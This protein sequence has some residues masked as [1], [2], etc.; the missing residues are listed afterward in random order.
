MLGLEMLFSFGRRSMKRGRSGGRKKR[1][2]SR[3]GRVVAVA[4]VEEKMRST[5]GSWRLVQRNSRNRWVGR[6]AALR[7]R[8]RTGK[9]VSDIGSRWSERKL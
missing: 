1:R 6:G 3:G 8:R 5:T 9:S 2:R 4:Q 7:A